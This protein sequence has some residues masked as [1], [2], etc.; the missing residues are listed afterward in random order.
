MIE[1]AAVSF[2]FSETAVDLLQKLS[3]YYGINATAVLEL[4]LRDQARKCKIQ[5]KEESNE[6]T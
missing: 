1:K 6:K 5:I 2:R 3:E 4:I